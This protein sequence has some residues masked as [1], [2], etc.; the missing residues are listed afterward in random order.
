MTYERVIP[1]DLFNESKLLK[2]M[3][4]LVLLVH[5][6]AVPGLDLWHDGG[7]FNIVQDENDGSISVSNVHLSGMRLHT[8]VN[9]REPWPLV[10]VTDD[11]EEIAVFEDDGQLTEAFT[12]HI[13]G[14]A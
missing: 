6:G 3:G 14:G 12:Q 8:P 1:R 13:K 4:R 5:D 11:W 7:P 10:L 2:C 9:C